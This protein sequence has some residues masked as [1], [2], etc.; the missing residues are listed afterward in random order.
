MSQQ[1][2]ALIQVKK[3]VGEKLIIVCHKVVYYNHNIFQFPHAT[4]WSDLQLT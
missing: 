1:P 4:Q 2:N 3:Y